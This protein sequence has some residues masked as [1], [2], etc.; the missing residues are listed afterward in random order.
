M[1]ARAPRD[2]QRFHQDINKVIFGWGAHFQ[3]QMV[4]G[5]W[6]QEA[7]VNNINWL[8]LRAIHLAFKWFQGKVSGHHVLILTDNVATKVHINCQGGTYSRALMWEAEQLG[9]WPEKHLS[10]RVEHISGRCE[11]PEKKTE[12]FFF[13]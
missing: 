5:Q 2:D 13:Q 12:K 11:G 1:Q 7:L 4:Q 3:S 6:S 9:L 8:E 10:I